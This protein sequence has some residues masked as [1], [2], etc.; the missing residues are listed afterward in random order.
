MRQRAS[1]SWSVG[2]HLH[3]VGAPGRA[4]ARMYAGMLGKLLSVPSASR[5]Q[6]KRARS[7]NHCV[8]EQSGV[9]PSY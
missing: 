2:V 8:T 5:M 9:M 4:R 3:H 7:V 6:R 1:F